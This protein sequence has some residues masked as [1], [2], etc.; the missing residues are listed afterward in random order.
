[1]ASR[2]ATKVERR[3]LLTA[4]SRSRDVPPRR[5]WFVDKFRITDMR[6]STVDHRWATGTGHLGVGPGHRQDDTAGLLFHFRGRS[7]HLVGI[8]TSDV[9]C[10]APPVVMEDLGGGWLTCHAEGE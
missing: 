1:L 3:I 5:D 9:G 6:I 7:W 2:P 8:G 4:A 10:G